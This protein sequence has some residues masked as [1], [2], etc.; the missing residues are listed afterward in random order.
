MTRAATGKTEDLPSKVSSVPAWKGDIFRLQT[1]GGGGYGDPA[2][3]SEAAKAAD[4]EN[5]YTSA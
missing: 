4:R 1:A 2:D 3:R 5:G